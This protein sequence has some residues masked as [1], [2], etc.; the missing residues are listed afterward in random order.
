MLVSCDPPKS[1]GSTPR[2]Q[3]TPTAPGA[4]TYTLTIA[5][6]VQTITRGEFASSENI[7]DLELLRDITVPTRLKGKLGAGK[8]IKQIIL[9]STII[10]IEDFAFWGHK[11]VQ[12]TLT[13]PKNVETI[14]EF[15]FRSLGSRIKRSIQLDVTFEK[16]S[17][18]KTI[19]KFAFAGGYF[20]R[21]HLPEKLETIGADA[22]SN[23]SIRDMS[24]F[25]IPSK[26]T[27]IG[28]LAF[29]S[30]FAGR[31]VE[32][33]IMSPTITLGTNLF[34]SSATKKPFST[35]K[36]HEDVYGNYTKTQLANRFG[37]VTAYQKLDG[38]AHAAK[39][40]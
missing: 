14:G 13:I 25:T 24:S 11:L 1:S 20:S 16:G 36:L 2:Y 15:S 28:D 19:K 37:A 17:R 22:F 33:T 3:L 32:L 34:V 39:T 35:I 40:P 31:T 4:K 23:S 9:P 6:G 12:K 38:T 5:K 27:R 29:L 7:K 26:V 8:S 30:V 21:I 10:A 18:L